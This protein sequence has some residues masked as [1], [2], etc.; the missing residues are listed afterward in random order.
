MI[1]FWIRE[2]DRWAGSRLSRLRH[3]SGPVLI[4]STHAW[5]LSV[6]MTDCPFGTHMKVIGV[7]EVSPFRFD[8]VRHGGLEQIA[9]PT[10]EDSDRIIA[11]NHGDT[12]GLRTYAYRS[13]RGPSTTGEGSVDGIVLSRRL[14]SVKQGEA[15]CADI[16]YT[17]YSV[18]TRVTRRGGDT[19][20]VCVPRTRPPT[21]FGHVSFA[22]AI[23]YRQPH[24]PGDIRVDVGSRD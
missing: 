13:G 12:V 5:M 18:T 14:C 3:V 21:V 11:V 19:S 2:G 7:A 16:E 23:G 9:S 17:R 24:A 22:H 1:T 10:H 4:S 15:F 6:D 8:R 20:A